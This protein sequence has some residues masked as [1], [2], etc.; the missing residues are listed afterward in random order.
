MNAAN[1]SM[2]SKW[3]VHADRRV[4]RNDGTTRA[5]AAAA[6]ILH[7]DV[8]E[9]FVAVGLSPDGRTRPSTLS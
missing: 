5:P 2:H 7:A 1:V 3:A 6:H 4:R 8:D 9:G